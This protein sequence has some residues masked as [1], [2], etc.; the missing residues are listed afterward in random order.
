MRNDDEDPLN[1]WCETCSFGAICC[2]KPK[3]V[4]AS[5]LKSNWGANRQRALFDG[6]KRNCFQRERWMEPIVYGQQ[7][8]SWKAVILSTVVFGYC[9]QTGAWWGPGYDGISDICSF[10]LN[11]NNRAFDECTFVC[12]FW[13]V[14]TNCTY[15]YNAMTEIARQSQRSSVPLFHKKF[16]SQ[17]PIRSYQQS[18]HVS[19]GESE[20]AWDK[21]CIGTE[22]GSH[23]VDGS[24]CWCAKK[25]SGKT[26]QFFYQEWLC[27][28][29]FAGNA[30]SECRFR[31]DCVGAEP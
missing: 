7:V 24:S 19:T 13:Y 27:A 17:K 21:C 12:W 6:G 18:R 15:E 5:F 16:P 9:H 23:T 3:G 14:Y 25:D 1:S 29:G 22:N 30:S 20:Y 2:L 11:R 10:A 8:L 28:D 31:D 26:S 4:K